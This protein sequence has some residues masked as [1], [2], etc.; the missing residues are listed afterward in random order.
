[1]KMLCP[2]CGSALPP[3]AINI[4]TDLAQCPE[5]GRVSRA[6]ACVVEDEISKDVLRQPPP[7]TWLRQ[8]ADAIVVG[9]T[10]RSKAAWGAALFTAICGGISMF[11]AY[12]TQIIDGKFD[13]FRT[14]FGI[15]FLLVTIFLVGTTIYMIFGRQE[16]HLNEDGGSG[17][18][19]VG[20]F[21]KR[22]RF[23]WNNLTRIHIYTTR[24]NHGN[25]SFKLILEGISPELKISLPECKDRQQFILNTIRYYH[26]QWRRWK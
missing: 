12:G 7:G 15:P 4:S 3:E 26:Q 9:A 2:Q 20:R 8:E 22:W 13:P 11:A 5:C 6:A 14:L 18:N 1:M 10:M 21:G 25:T 19:G 17:F 23:A 16:W 24:D